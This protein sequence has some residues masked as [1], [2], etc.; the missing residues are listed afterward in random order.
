MN[1]PHMGQYPYASR[2]E[3]SQPGKALTGISH[4]RDVEPGLVKPIAVSSGDMY[5]NDKR[6]KLIC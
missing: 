4:K 1:G 2:M 6:M 3:G 5:G